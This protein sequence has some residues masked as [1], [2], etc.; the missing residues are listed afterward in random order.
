M[1]ATKL[2]AQALERIVREVVAEVTAE[3]KRAPLAAPIAAAAGDACV[4]PAPPLHG[5]DAPADAALLA[6]LIARTPSGIATGRAGTRMP[7]ERY[8]S[9]REGHADAKDAVHSDLPEAF[10]AEQR[11]LSLHSRCKDRAEYLLYPNH[12]RRLDEASRAALAPLEGSAPDVAVIV[13]DGLSPNAIAVNGAD[14]VA[15]LGKALAAAG[16]KTSPVVYVKFARIGVQDEIGV[17]LRAR[18]TVMLVGE[19]PGLG[20]GDSL[21]FYLAVAPRLDQDNAEKN[22]I[23]NVRPIGIRPAEAAA[24]SLEILKRSFQRGKGGVDLGVGYGRVG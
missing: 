7:T 18:A 20:T 10:V 19:R 13:G 2:S 8:L 9:M 22:C 23:S 5:V 17:L 11:W 4:R 14:C 24:L 1:S 6:A 21:S 16:Y 12:G 15:E 3:A